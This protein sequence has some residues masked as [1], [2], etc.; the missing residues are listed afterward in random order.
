MMLPIRVGSA[1]VTITTTLTMMM[2]DAGTGAHTRIQI[3]LN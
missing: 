2:E 3:V 1:P